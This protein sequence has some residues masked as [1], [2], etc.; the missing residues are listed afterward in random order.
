MEYMKWL[1]KEISET[2]KK[3]KWLEE[4]KQ[5]ISSKEIEEK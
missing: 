3:L 4:A 1:D 5:I 2:N